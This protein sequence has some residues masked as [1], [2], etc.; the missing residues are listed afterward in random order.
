MTVRTVLQFTCDVCSRHLLRDSVPKGWAVAI[1]IDKFTKH[2]KVYHGCE[3]CTP[4]FDA[5][6]VRRGLT[7]TQPAR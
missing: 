7:V 3:R 5:M 2:E 4:Q 1:S 6:I